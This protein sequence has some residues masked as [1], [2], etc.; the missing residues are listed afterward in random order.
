MAQVAS[1]VFFVAERDGFLDSL[2]EYAYPIFCRQRV[3]SDL[4]GNLERI[5]LQRFNNFGAEID[6]LALCLLLTFFIVDLALILN[7]T[8]TSLNLSL[9]ATSVG[10]HCAAF[11]ALTQAL[12]HVQQCMCVHPNA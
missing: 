9:L 6:E 11:R 4:D 7:G 2:D 12:R 8:D 1:I 5:V 10:A 3:E